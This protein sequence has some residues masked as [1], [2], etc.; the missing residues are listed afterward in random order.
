MTILIVAHTP[1]TR[2]VAST[3]E[4]RSSM[5]GFTFDDP[6]AGLDPPKKWCRELL[7]GW[8]GF[9]ETDPYPPRILY[10]VS[11]GSHSVQF[12]FA[13]GVPLGIPFKLVRIARAL[14]TVLDDA[15]RAAVERF[16][17]R[18]LTLS[19]HSV[20]VYPLRWRRDELERASLRKLV[21]E[22]AWAIIERYQPFGA[23]RSLGLLHWRSWLER[24]G[25]IY[26]AFPPCFENFRPFYT[27][28]AY[29]E[30]TEVVHELEPWSPLEGV[31][32]LV[33]LRFDSTRHDP[34]LRVERT[35]LLHVACGPLPHG[36]Q[37]TGATEMVEDIR[38]VIT[39]LA[40]LHPNEWR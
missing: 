23:G 27:Y 33:R 4:R 17:G 1:A 8:L 29:A 11:T 39:E 25:R 31:K 38:K 5:N 7:A 21:S 30:P 18:P 37:Y 24:D 22:A 32:E 28:A 35:P 10:D 34:Q 13:R 40:E 15:V 9:L 14:R 36:V 19:E 2:G 20:I 3:R 6:L 16:L 12:D 26:P